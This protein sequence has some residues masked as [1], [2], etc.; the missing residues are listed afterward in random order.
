MPACRPAARARRRSWPSS[1]AG[2]ALLGEQLALAQPEVAALRRAGVPAPAGY[3]EAVQATQAFLDLVQQDFATGQ[4]QGEARAFFAAGTQA[5][6]AIKTLAEGASQALNE[7]LTQREAALRRTQWIAFALA[8]AC[9]LSLVHCGLARRTEVPGSNEFARRGRDLDT[10]NRH[11][12][13]HRRGT[14]HRS[15]HAPEPSGRRADG[16]GGPAQGR[17]TGR[18]ARPRVS[19]RPRAATTPLARQAV[20]R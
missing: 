7:R 8:A 10:M 20:S 13:L 16:S 6:Q 11:P 17:L 1:G 2:A 5:V 14:D 4:P 3:E 12:C 18:A 9:F 15:R 19:S